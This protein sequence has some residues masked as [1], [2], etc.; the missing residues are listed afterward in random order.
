M[1]TKKKQIMP[2]NTPYLFAI[3]TYFT[4]F[5]QNFNSDMTQEQFNSIDW[6]RGNA[7]RLTNGKEYPVAKVRNKTRLLLYSAEYESYFIADYR[8]VEER[9]SDKIDDATETP[10][11]Q[12]QQRAGTKDIP[13]SDENAAAA[14]QSPAARESIAAQVSAGET[15]APARKKRPRIR[16]ASQTPLHIGLSK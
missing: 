6:H 8:I 14:A 4:T 2:Y 11:Q 1:L 12:T 10:N 16:V 5:A 7:V 15:P 9:T 3:P 13:A